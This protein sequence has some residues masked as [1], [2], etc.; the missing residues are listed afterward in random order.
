[1]G[2]K[3]IFENP[4]RPIW[5]NAPPPKFDH[6]PIFFHF[7]LG[8]PP[9]VWVLL[10]IFPKLP[11]ITFRQTHVNQGA[12]A[13]TQGGILKTPWTISKFAKGFRSPGTC[14]NPPF[15]HILVFFAIFTFQNLPKLK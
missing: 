14:Q 4:T 5:A 10:R 6:S 12:D 15:C 2:S 7:P 9:V 3:S 13:R 1:M 8:I 11:L